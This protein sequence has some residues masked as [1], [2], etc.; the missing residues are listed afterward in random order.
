MS[1]YFPPDESKLNAKFQNEPEQ[2]IGVIFEY[3]LVRTSYARSV[4]L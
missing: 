3:D 1:K 2:T 4:L